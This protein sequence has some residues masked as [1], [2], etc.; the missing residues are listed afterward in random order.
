MRGTR[1]A[2][3]VAEMPFIYGFDFGGKM[4]DTDKQMSDVMSKYW[5]NFIKTGNPNAEGLPQW[6]VYN[7]STASVMYMKDGFRLTEA[8]NMP[9]MTFLQRYFS[10]MRRAMAK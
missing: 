5:I 6:D 4:S 7:P 2:T 1:G 3:H 8:P 10:K 9:Q